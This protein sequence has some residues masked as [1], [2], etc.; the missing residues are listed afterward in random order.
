VDSP[1]AESKNKNTHR[2]S[3]EREELAAWKPHESR[4]RAA[5]LTA[6]SPSLRL[7]ARVSVHLGLTRWCWGR[8]ASILFRVYKPVKPTAIANDNTNPYPSA[9]LAM[10]LSLWPYWPT[11][12][13]YSYNKPPPSSSPF[14]SSAPPTHHP[15]PQ[16]H[17]SLLPFLFSGLPSRIGS[18]QF[19]AA[20]AR[21]Q[22][23]NSTTFQ[24]TLCL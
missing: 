19:S 24:S 23:G 9:S 22:I 14:A 15:P 13:Q 12:Q 20:F 17:H 16:S 18:L 1:E 10:R 5:V 7:S 6:T 21:K 4:A 2:P 8:G 3:G 11:Q